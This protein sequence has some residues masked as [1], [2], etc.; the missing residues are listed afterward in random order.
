MRTA[1]PRS[2][3]LAARSERLSGLAAIGLGQPLLAGDRR[4]IERQRLARGHRG[5]AAVMA[6]HG[7]REVPCLLL[8]AEGIRSLLHGQDEVCLLNDMHAVEVKVGE[9]P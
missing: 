2:G 3:L 4:Y 1:R 6:D 7:W 8:G 5:L 9:V